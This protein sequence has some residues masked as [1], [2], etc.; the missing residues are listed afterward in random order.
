MAGRVGRVPVAVAPDFGHNFVSETAK[1]FGTRSSTTSPPPHSPAHRTT[2]FLHFGAIGLFSNNCIGRYSVT[3]NEIPFNSR[4]GHGDLC[5]NSIGRCICAVLAS[6]A[7]Q[8]CC[9]CCQC[10]HRHCLAVISIRL[11]DD[12]GNSELRPAHPNCLR[13]EEAAA[14]TRRGR[15]LPHAAT[16]ARPA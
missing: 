2:H 11:N 6:S 13:S 8:C 12:D 14:R 10:C 5:A 3:K 15:S 4:S 16:V 7:Q 9:C 1:T